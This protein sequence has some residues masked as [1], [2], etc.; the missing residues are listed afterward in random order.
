M[1]RMTED[2]VIPELNKVAITVYFSHVLLM[3]WWSSALLA[4]LVLLLYQVISGLF[5][6]RHETD[7]SKP[8]VFCL[9]NTFIMANLMRFNVLKS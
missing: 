8:F 7:L 1:L 4:V 2:H 3:P 6:C 9:T 5:G